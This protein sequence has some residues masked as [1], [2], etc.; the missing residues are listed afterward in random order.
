MEAARAVPLPRMASMNVSHSALALL[1][2]EAPAV[3]LD[4]LMLVRLMELAEALVISRVGRAITSVR[5]GR[6][7]LVLFG[8]R[9][10]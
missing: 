10:L 3:A 8:S 5:L 6:I 1:S 7:L 4:S 2:L 9:T